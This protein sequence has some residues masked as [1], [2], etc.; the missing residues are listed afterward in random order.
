MLE[1]FLRFIFG[2]TRIKINGNGI[3]KFLTKIV[4]LD[5]KVFNIDKKS[6]T[7]LTFECYRYLHKDVA[8]II[9]EFKYVDFVMQDKG[10]PVILVKYKNRW[11]LIAGALLFF[12]LFYTV[13]LFVWEINIVG[14]D[15]ISEQEILQ[16]L[17]EKGFSVGVYKGK[18]DASEI[19]NAFLYDYDKVSWMSINIIGTSATVEIRENICKVKK[20]DTSEPSNIYASRD[21]VIASVSAYMGYSVVSVGDTVTAGDLVVSGEY[22]DK[23]GKEYKLHSYASVMAYTTH[24]FSVSIP[25]T[26][27]EQQKTGKSK[28]YY[29][30][31]LIRL[32]LPLYFKE[33]ISYNTYSVN[34]TIKQFR[35]GDSLVLPFSVEKISYTETENISYT[36]TK[37][38]ALSDAYE[39]LDDLENNLVGITVLDK[40]YEVTESS[41]GIDVKVVLDCYEDIG[42][43][44]P[45]S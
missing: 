41:E 35:L 13:T 20:L 9:H 45:I 43:E 22:T 34:R 12:V 32:S 29:K 42:I 30:I 39:Q 21:G 24:T 10:L 38:A 4:A 37:E 7:E 5:L 19:E 1:K 16:R 25:Y 2:T 8:K 11:G 27:L 28:N 23:Y 44:M 31:N 14:C 26:A 36:K 3:E 6:D 17:D 15:E 18:I 40:E 33:N